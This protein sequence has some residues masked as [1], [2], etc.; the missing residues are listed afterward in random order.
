MKVLGLAGSFAA[1]K[2]SLA[3]FLEENYKI[4]HISTSDIVREV[5]RE[6]YDSIER[7]VL[8]KTANEIR[9]A[10]GVGS[11]SERALLRYQ[12]YK[13]DFP[14]G[15]CVSGFRAWGEAEVVRWAGGTIVFVDAPTKLRYQRTIDRGRDS[16]KD[17]TY[18]QFLEREAQENGGINPVFNLSAIKEKADIVFDNSSDLEDFLSRAQQALGL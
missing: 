11:L 9:E 6:R 8:Y 14:G 16:E 4:K 5:A 17:N 15:V 10:E 12:D 7:P 13:Q 3:H 2:D 18:Q 1:G